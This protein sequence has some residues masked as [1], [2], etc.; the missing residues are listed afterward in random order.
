MT[1]TNPLNRL[2]LERYPRS[3]RYDPAWILENQMGPNP[4]W[5]VEALTEVMPVPT[6]WRV[7]DLGAGTALTSIFLAKEFGVSVVAVDLWIDPSEN[8]RRIH[9]AGVDQDVLPIRAEAHDLPFGHESFD[10]IVSVDAYHYFGTGE[11]DLPRFAD[12]LRPG[13]RIGIVVPGLV[14]ELGALPSHLVDVWDPACWTFHSPDWWRRLWER[15]GRLHVDHADLLRDGWKEWL[16]WLDVCQEMGV[17]TDPNEV[18]MVRDDAG[19][20]LGFTRIVASRR[21]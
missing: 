7:L 13:G 9:A 17:E 18:R 6:G 14:A 3:A 19:R 16:L 21:S 8:Q 4:L 2:A 1:N 10:A 15:S 20:N 11:L 12:L 5:L